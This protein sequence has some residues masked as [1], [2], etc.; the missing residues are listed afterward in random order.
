MNLLSRYA[1]PV[2]I[3]FQIQDD[4][5]GVFGSEKKIGKSAASDIEEGKQTFLVLKA[6]ELA[7]SKQKKQLDSILGKKNLTN[8]EIRIFQDILKSTEALEYSKKMAITYLAKGK[9]EIKKMAFLP[10]AKKFIMGLT[11]YLEGREI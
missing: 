3:A 5:L 2:G 4:I 10:D 6:R 9:R 8:M 7:N 1:I 11:E